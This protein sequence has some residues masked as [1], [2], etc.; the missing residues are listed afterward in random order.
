M[1]R[2]TP[3]ASAT[4]AADHP[5]AFPTSLR[6]TSAPD[7]SARAHRAEPHAAH[8]GPRVGSA[9]SHPS[10]DRIRASK[11]VK[12]QIAAALRLAS[13][14]TSTPAMARTRPPVPQQSLQRA[15]A[16]PLDSIRPPPKFPRFESVSKSKNFKS[17]NCG[18]FSTTKSLTHDSPAHTKIGSQFT[19]AATLRQD[20]FDA[21]SILFRAN[22]SGERAL[23]RLAPGLHAETLLIEVGRLHGDRDFPRQLFVAA[24]AHL[25]AGEREGDHLAHGFRGA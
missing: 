7:C 23:L 25:A 13:C 11:D 1:P 18:R 14:R 24:L 2:M 8:D 16:A 9:S 10:S 12:L 20:E 5:S 3:A 15:W 21:Y 22:E 6:A 19:C 17:A 4:P